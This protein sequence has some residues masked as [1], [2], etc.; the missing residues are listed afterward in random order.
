MIAAGFE[1]SRDLP[2]EVKKYAIAGQ[3]YLK[4]SQYIE[5]NMMVF[6]KPTVARLPAHRRLMAGHG[7]YGGRV[8]NQNGGLRCSGRDELPA[9]YE[10]LLECSVDKPGM[11]SCKKNPR[12]IPVK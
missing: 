10:A 11:W 12:A 3:K 1:F 7:S 2:Q 9:E 4:D 5:Y 8:D 6:I